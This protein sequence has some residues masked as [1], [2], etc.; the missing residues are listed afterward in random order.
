[1]TVMN[2]QA[3]PGQPTNYF[4]D[5]FVAHKLSGLTACGAPELSENPKWLSAFILSSVFIATMSPKPRAYLF[6]FIRR[7][8]GAFSAYRDARAALIDYVAS[9]RNVVSPYFKA[10]LDFELCIAQM[11]QGRELIMAATREKFFTPNDGSDSERLHTLY[12]DS[13]HAERM[14]A[15]G[16]LPTEATATIWVSNQGLE[17]SRATLSFVELHELLLGMGRFADQLLSTLG[18]KRADTQRGADS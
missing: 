8:E 5:N 3:G 14:I 16:K 18:A 11:Q 10:L 2:L 15:G 6:N 9:P 13:K 12:I 17:S 4:L 1:M 7:A